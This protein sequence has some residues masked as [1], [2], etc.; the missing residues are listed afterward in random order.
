M[1]RWKQPCG[2]L[3]EVLKKKGGWPSSLL[4]DQAQG[5]DDTAATFTER[6]QLARKQADLLR[7]IIFGL[8]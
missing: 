6:A 1:R 3:Y 8:G 2:L 4:Q 7:E 5:N